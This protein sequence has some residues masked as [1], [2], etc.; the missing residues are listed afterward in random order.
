MVTN[1][2]SKPAGSSNTFSGAKKDKGLGSSR[3]SEQALCKARA[4]HRIAILYIFS[5]IIIILNYQ[6]IRFRKIGLLPACSFLAWDRS[7]LYPCSTRTLGHNLATWL[8]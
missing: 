1:E 3:S 6:L 5:F 8:L 7:A 2:A 4:P